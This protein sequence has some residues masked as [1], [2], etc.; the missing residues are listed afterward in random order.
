MFSPFS[1]KENIICA[2]DLQEQAAGQ[3]EGCST[4]CSCN[5]FANFYVLL[6]CAEQFLKLSLKRGKSYGQETLDDE[7]ERDD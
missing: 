7:R 6:A 4:A 3:H 5:P 1:K 2:E